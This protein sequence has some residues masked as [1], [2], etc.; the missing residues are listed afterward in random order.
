[1]AKQ[2]N[3]LILLSDQL[4]RR[5]LGTYGHEQID[6]PNIDRL[7]AN[8]ACFEN[9]C[10]SYPICVPFRF[11]LMTGQ[12]AQSRLVPGI[13]W[14]MSPA[15]RTL[16]DEFNEAGY[17]TLYVGKWHLYGDTFHMP[18]YG[19]HHEG[20]RPVPRSHQGRWQHWRGFELRN[21]PFHTCYFVDDDP[22]PRRVPGYQTDG[23]CDIAMDFLANDRDTSKPF[24]AVVSV[25][26]PHPPYDAPQEN[27]DRWAERDL[28][29]P[30]NFMTA[31]DDFGEGEEPLT[32]ENRA[33][34]I[35][36]FRRY[37]A[38]VENLDAN[39][40]RMMDF[41]QSHGLAE[42][43]IVLLLSDHGDHLGS[44]CLR[45]RKQY[46]YEESVGIPLIVAG[47]GIASGQR[48]ALP[49][50][51][52]D[53]FPTI[54]GLAG[55]CPRDAVPGGNLSGV[56]TGT[57]DE[58]DRPGV[59][60]GFV[61]ELRKEQAFCQKTWRAFRSERYCYIVFGDNTGAEP[62]GFFDLQN[63]PE[64]MENRIGSA[65]H[66]ELIAQHHRWLVD[67]LNRVEDDY[68]LAAALGCEARHVYPDER[69]SAEELPFTQD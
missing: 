67:E 38:M 1:M 15:E 31:F 26:P 17:E 40:G 56:V 60:L 62:A 10:S 69:I 53:L 20:R 23:L 37:H 50:N 63:D 7:A 44:H 25:E 19:R 13:E 64:Q 14:R 27:L 16:A 66:Q 33:S 24:C 45:S 39:V 12:T 35:V 11:T 65:E 32:E 5:S 55:L 2:P 30:E 36:E 54:L 42:D 61:S 29:L 52:E 3:I 59:L 22:T 34:R 4:R 68:P 21:D 18:G 49:S 46:P 47:P 51:T 41:L 9:A 57:A 28:V 48:I 8:G 6:T 58:I 43:T